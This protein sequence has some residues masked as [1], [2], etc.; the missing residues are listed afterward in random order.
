MT[1]YYVYWYRLPEHSDP[2]RDGYIG[3]TN[4]VTR[5]HKEHKQAANAG[6]S[7]THFCNALCK[8]GNIIHEVLHK[9]TK[10]EAL[11]FE[12]YYR[13]E[14]NVG[15]NT[16]AGG[17]D[18]LKSLHEEEVTLYHQKDPTKT[19]TFESASEA[20]RKLGIKA[21][22]IR[23]AVRSKSPTYGFD[24]WAILFDKDIDRFVTKTIGQAISERIVGTKRKKPSHFKGV[25][26]RWSKEDR[27]RIGAQHKGKKISKEQVETVRAKHRASHP[28]CKEI[29]L[30]HKDTPDVEHTYHS[31]SEASRE[32]GIPLSR[33]KS[34]A[35]RTLGVQGKDG[36]KIVK[37]GAE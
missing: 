11:E 33:L 19:Y 29:V 2:H 35:Q 17:G 22:R 1:D 18:L 4:D 27:K 8:Y 14:T 37:L 36:W 7:K 5:R 31:I 10:D 12:F 6:V 25:T 15:W 9:C 21:A 30:V 13:S 34:K 26:D 32:L 23:K 3:I 28:K 16:A 24:G 20:S